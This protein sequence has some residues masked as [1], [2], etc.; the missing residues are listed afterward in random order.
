M[1]KSWLLL[2]IIVGVLPLFAGTHASGYQNKP[3][4]PVSAQL[5][6]L[7]P[8][9]LGL[10]LLTLP[11]SF[12]DSKRK[13]KAARREAEDSNFRRTCQNWDPHS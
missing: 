4:S 10:F 8:L 1:M 7:G 5:T 6:T 11:L 3:P 13:S 2:S 12:H 9:T